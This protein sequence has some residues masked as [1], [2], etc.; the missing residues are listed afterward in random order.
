MHPPVTM[1]DVKRHLEWQKQ[2]KEERKTVA[3]NMLREISELCSEP[4]PSPPVPQRPSREMTR[5]EEEQWKRKA[6]LWAYKTKKAILAELHQP[7]AIFAKT[8]TEYFIPKRYKKAAINMLKNR[9]A[10]IRE[11]GWHYETQGWDNW[12]W[13]KL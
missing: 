4:I 12:V 9:L 7:F 3:L 6:S 13:M 5:E 8:T 1:E 2:K 10:K 11:A